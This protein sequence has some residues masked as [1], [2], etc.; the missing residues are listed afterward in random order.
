MNFDLNLTITAI[1]ALIALVSPIITTLINN[2]YE[3]KNR[4]IDVYYS[5]QCKALD[6]FVKCTL[7]YYG[8]TLTWGEMSAYTT[9]LNNL[10][11]Y[12]NN[13]DD[14]LF[15]Q[16]DNARQKSNIKEYK[17]LLNIIVKE[18]SKQISKI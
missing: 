14:S 5:N 12:F 18:L 2:H 3:F 4:K 15:T 6:N 13:L 10:Y 1:I 9:A 11:I 17:Q 8:E 7:N 16:L